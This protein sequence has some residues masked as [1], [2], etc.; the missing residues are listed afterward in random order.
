MHLCND[1]GSQP[2]F[3]WRVATPLEESARSWSRK[4]TQI[5]HEL[6][7]DV[8]TP[9]IDFDKDEQIVAEYRRSKQAERKQLK[10]KAKKS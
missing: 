6:H 3:R 2:S 4:P 7:K 1:N 5:V 8:Y 9:Y 10:A